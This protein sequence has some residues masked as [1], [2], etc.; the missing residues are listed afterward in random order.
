MARGESEA[1]EASSG[2]GKELMDEF[3]AALRSPASLQSFVARGADPERA[4]VQVWR[5]ALLWACAAGQEDFVAEF[6]NSSPFQSLVHT[7]RDADEYTALHRAVVGG[8]L[9]V[10]RLLSRIAYYPFPVLHA[11][12]KGGWTAL[13]LAVCANDVQ[14]VDLLLK[15]YEGID[16]PPRCLWDFRDD[17]WM[18]PLQYG[19]IQESQNRAPAGELSNPPRVVRLLARSEAFRVHL[20]AVDY[21]RRSALHMACAHKSAAVEELLDVP[22]VDSNAVDCCAYTPLHWAVLAGATD[23]VRAFTRRATD[24]TIRTTEEDVEGRPVLQI[25]I[26]N[27]EIDHKVGRDLQKLLLTVPEVKDEVERLYRD[28]QVFVDAANAILVG[29]A[30]IASVTF[31]GW[32]QPPHGDDAEVR[33]FWAFNSLSFFFALATVMAGAG[34]VLPM[35]DVYIGNTVTSIRRWLALTSFLLLV[36]V[37]LVL[38][39]FA[40]AGF[41]SL[42][43]IPLL[44]GNMVATTAVGTVVCGVIGLLFLR[45]LSRILDRRLQEYVDDFK[46]LFAGLLPTMA[47][48]RRRSMVEVNALL[49]KS[50]AGIINSAGADFPRR[51]EGSYHLANVVLSFDDACEREASLKARGQSQGQSQGVSRRQGVSSRHEPVDESEELPVMKRMKV[52]EQAY[53]EVRSGL[54][55]EEATLNMLTLTDLCDESNDNHNGLHFWSDFAPVHCRKRAR[56]KDLE[57]WGA[58]QTGIHD[59]KMHLEEENTKFYYTVGSFDD[60]NL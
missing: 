10:A 17:A 55:E 35:S 59:K 20:N 30:L 54:N 3:R 41:A 2:T 42:P 8:H 39:A 15:W 51:I 16:L 58:I 44:R 40:A 37:V 47:S 36:S 4:P 38:G 26:E 21:F 11:R 49:N 45:R 25:A 57:L 12:T 48:P 23:A 34:T 27:R 29:A 22:A 52:F 43:G 33:I 13:H 9:G 1:R 6:L 19:V 24:R 14:M 18:T 7:A 53:Q 5:K 28:R 46:L 31:G 32:L 60:W 56:K 50:R